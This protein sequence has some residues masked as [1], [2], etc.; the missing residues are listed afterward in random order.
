MGRDR[1][2]LSIVTLGYVPRH[3]PDPVF[4]VSLL[5][6]TDLPESIIK[7]LHY[8]PSVVLMAFIIPDLLA[9]GGTVDLSLNNYRLIAGITAIIV[10]RRFNNTIY[11]VGSGIAVLW[12][13]EA[14]FQ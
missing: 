2:E 3:I 8:V 9:Y 4:H 1:N 5:R 10:A 11:T 7:A 13:L 14:F 6:Q 12:A